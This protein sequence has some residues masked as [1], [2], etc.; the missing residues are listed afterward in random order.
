[1]SIE[2]KMRALAVAL[3]GDDWRTPTA[4]LLG[5]SKETVRSWL[6]RENS[7]YGPGQEHLDVLLREAE[8]RRDALAAAIASA[9]D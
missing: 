7:R 1:M 6:V 3:Y 5:V 2:E 8:A 9:S 4:E